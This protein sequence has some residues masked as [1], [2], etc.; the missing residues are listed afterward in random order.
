MAPEQLGEGPIGPHTDMFAWAV[1]MVYAASG[2]PA[3]GHRSI[4]QV[5]NRILHEEPDLGALDGR[6]RPA[7]AACLSKDPARRPTARRLMDELMGHN[8]PAVSLADPASGS[9]SERGSARA[10]GLSSGD[11]ASSAG[12][13]D[14]GRPGTMR[15]PASAPSSYA[16]GPGSPTSADAGTARLPASGPAFSG[17]APGYPG[18]SASTTG[19]PE[20]R[21]G[22]TALIIAVVVAVFIALIAGIGAM[23][24]A[25]GHGKDP[26]AAAPPP[27][28]KR[29]RHPSKHRTPSPSRT[30]SRKSAVATKAAKPDPYTP[31]R[32]CGGG[33]RVVGVHGLGDATTYLL[34]N[35]QAGA[36][37]VVT[38]VPKSSGKTFLSASLVV[39]G[40][41][42]GSRSGAFPF[43]A[44]PVRLPARGKCVTWGGASKTAK[45]TSGWSHCGK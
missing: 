20:R 40:G 13:S 35:T 27:S 1:T 5:I 2:V 23:A 15:L 8:G 18:S 32:V 17:G 36:N 39:K 4:P 45:W 41:S 30:P 38:M 16:G 25:G 44:G 37:C 43:Y 6:L 12:G 28:A 29:S 33:Y 21:K 7:V 19:P 9:A 42:R 22:R 3:F 24:A 31:Q 34:Y 26:K 14:P 11:S 10:P